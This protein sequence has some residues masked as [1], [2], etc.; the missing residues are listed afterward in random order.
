[1]PSIEVHI[2]QSAEPP[3]GIG[4]PVVP[5]VGPAVS[6]AIL[7]ATGKRLRTLPLSFR[8]NKMMIRVGSSQNSDPRLGR[9]F[10]VLHC[11]PGNQRTR[12]QGPSLCPLLQ[13]GAFCPLW[14]L[15][16]PFLT[17]CTRRFPLDGLRRDPKRRS[18]DSGCR[19]SL[20]AHNAY[21]MGYPVLHILPLSRGLSNVFFAPSVGAHPEMGSM[22]RCISW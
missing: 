14:T 19:A 7:A 21:P 2:V 18:A 17:R 6:H 5:T 22:Q 4:E 3:I 16:L 10:P 11:R 8:R 13:L 1:M 15:V 20:G 12:P 9:C